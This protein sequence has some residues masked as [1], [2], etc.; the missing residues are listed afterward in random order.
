MASLFI[1]GMNLLYNSTTAYAVTKAMAIFLE[2]CCGFTNYGESVSSGHFNTYEKTGSNGGFTGAATPAG[3]LST[4]ASASHT[5][6]EYLILDDGYHDPVTFTFASSP[7][8]DTDID[9]TGSVTADVMKERIIAA[10]N[11]IRDQR[12]LW[13]DATDGGTD[14]VTLTN[15]RYTTRGNGSLWSTDS[16]IGITQP[17]GGLDGWVLEDTTASAFVQADVGKWAVVVDPTNPVNNGVYRIV[18][19]IS[20]DA[21]ELDFQANKDNGEAFVATG[22]TLSWYVFK[23]DYDMPTTA[24]NYF[25]LESPAGWAVRIAQYAYYWYVTVAVDGSWSN[26]RTIGT[27]KFT[28]NAEAANGRGQ[29]NVEADQAGT[30]L[31]MWSTGLISNYQPEGVVNQNAIFI[32]T[33]VPVEPDAEQWENVVL[34]GCPNTSVN[35]AQQLRR[36]STTN[37]VGVGRAWDER[38]FTQYLVYMVD[39]S[40]SSNGEGHR[41]PIYQTWLTEP[42]RRLAPRS[43]E[44]GKTELWE[45][46]WLLKDPYNGAWDGKYE[47]LGYMSGHLNSRVMER[48]T[49]RDN[50]NTFPFVPDIQCNMA[51]VKDKLHISG[52]FVVNWPAGITR[53]V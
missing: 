37:T 42:N 5:N 46:T 4:I 23:H 3:E 49:N 12:L 16:A 51:G 53:K 27:N 30:F 1:R 29:V 39:Q 11:L 9:I 28:F 34:V 47:W 33:V 17:S 36:S 48:Y 14:T 44:I 20:A 52:G 40:Y 22:S 31:N 32:D 2:K 50:Y 6:G 25:Q 15:F 24:G 8:A 26:G 38:N 35:G 10:V 45:G 7:S 13:I 19:Y 21:V 18:R 41:E 43:Y